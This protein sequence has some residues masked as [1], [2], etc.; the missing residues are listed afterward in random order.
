MV[1]KIAAT[2]LIIFSGFYGLIFFF[3]DLARGESWITRLLIAFI[4]YLVFSTIIN[5]LILPKW[6]YSF[7]LMWGV[8]L[9]AILNLGTAMS[10]GPGWVW[11]AFKMVYVPL[12]GTITGVL[13]VRFIK[14]K[15]VS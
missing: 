4:Y 7:L 3:A 14:P 10:E 12:L 9:V 8:T 6:K 2:V 1:R 13:I 15:K 11:D 5:W